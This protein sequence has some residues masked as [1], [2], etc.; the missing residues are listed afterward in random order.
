MKLQISVSLLAVVGA[1]LVLACGREDKPVES[2]VAFL[3]TQISSPFLVNGSLADVAAGQAKLHKMEVGSAKAFQAQRG[4]REFKNTDISAVYLTLEERNELIRS[5]K[6]KFAEPVRKVTR[7]ATQSAP[8]SW[9]LDRIDQKSLPLDSSFNHPNGSASNVRAYVIDTGIDPTHP[10]F[11]GR[12][13]AGYS[14][15]KDGK[16]SFDCE[17]H[18]THVAGTVGGKTFGVAKKVVLYP[19]RVLDCSGSGTTEG[20]V[21]GMEWVIGERNKFPNIPM[22]AN[23]SLGGEADQA[24]DAAAAKMIQARIFLAVAAGNSSED[25]CGT[26]PARAPNAFTVGASDKN[27]NKAGFSNF[28]SCV[29]GYAPGSAIKSAQPNNGSAFLS[30]TSMASPHVAGVG[31][32]VLAAFPS[33]TA[34]QVTS[35]IKTLGIAGGVKN[36]SAKLAENNLLQVEQNETAP[37]PTPVPTAVPTKGPTPRPTPGEFNRVVNDTISAR[38]FKYY[39]IATRELPK[40]KI[41]LQVQMKGTPSAQLD[42]TLDI[43]DPA[44]GWWKPIASTNTSGSNDVLNWNGDASFLRVGVAAKN[45][46]GS[47]ELRI[48]ARN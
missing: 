8:P 3:S 7:F 37:L 14:S 15:I 45:G 31:A 48:Q 47:F 44:S 34:A 2:E 27:D 38:G 42:L 46:G 39:S 43:W 32:L 22:V 25:A 10:D 4:A 23:M 9:G 30:G 5:G 40:G 35:R 13:Q 11:E 28:G 17:G 36:L 26:S 21:E 12:V 29:D 19:V 18:G 33:Y 6:V 24:L 41:A 1:G 16:G 20:V